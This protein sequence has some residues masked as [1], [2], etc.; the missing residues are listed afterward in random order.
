MY[1]I[2]RNEHMYFNIIHI[3]SQERGMRSYKHKYFKPYIYLLFLY[4]VNFLLYYIFILVRN[5]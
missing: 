1:E 5:K 2:I 4:L 3:S